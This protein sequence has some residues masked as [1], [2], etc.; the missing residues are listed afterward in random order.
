MPPRLADAPEE[1]HR[2]NPRTLMPA[3]NHI[4]LLAMLAW[5]DIAIRY[6]QSV[7]GVLWAILMPTAIVMAGIV[8]RL[9]ISESSGRSMQSRELVLILVKAAPWAFFAATLRFGTN[10]LIV[11]TNLVCKIFFPRLILP[12][13]AVL[14]QLFD[15]AIA[16]SI[17]ALVLVATGSGSVAA[18]GWVPLLVALLVLLTAGLVAFL[19]AASLFFRDVKY[20]VE[21][22]LMFAIFVT[23][24]L[25]E[26]TAFG[27]WRPLLLLNPVAPLLEGLATTIVD[28]RATDLPWLA[29]SATVAVLVFVGS[30]TFFRRVESSFAEYA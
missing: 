25:Y 27:R 13:A 2:M 11:N 1:T 14:S 26:S 19:S 16:F 8:L 21:V 9:A 28:G 24:V 22:A 20:L 10:C 7:L 23:P 30:V 29:Y 5:R 12:F 17:V 4:D 3:R 15:F 6:K 18:L